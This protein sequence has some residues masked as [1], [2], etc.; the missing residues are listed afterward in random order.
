LTT[1]GSNV[2]F[3]LN[4][5]GLFGTATAFPDPTAVEAPDPTGNYTG[6][7]IVNNAAYV[8]SITGISIPDNFILGRGVRVI[9]CAFEVENLTSVL[10][11]Q[12]MVTLYRAPMLYQGH[13]QFQVQAKTGVTLRQYTQ[14]LMRTLPPPKLGDM[15]LLPGTKQWEA[16]KGAYVPGLLDPDLMEQFDAGYMR[17]P[18][19]FSNSHGAAAGGLNLLHPVWADVSFFDAA[20]TNALYAASFPNSIIPAGCYF[21]G[22]HRESVLNVTVK[23]FIETMP[24]WNDSLIVNAQISAR[25]DPAALQAYAIAIQTLDAG[26]TFDMNPFG[27]WFEKAMSILSSAAAQIGGVIGG[28]LGTAGGTLVGGG[29]TALGDWNK[30]SRTA[31]SRVWF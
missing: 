29:L 30:R 3:P 28:P 8:R 20:G 11:L 22:L 27:E 18:M 23:W 26:A 17:T 12:G 2:I 7:T 5:T 31:G 25:Y 1:F 24:A 6:I 13:D 19:V 21:E 4:I 15:L 16:Q 9:G 14:A 10:N